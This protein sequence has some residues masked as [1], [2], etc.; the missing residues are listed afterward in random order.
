[1]E[2]HN[3]SLV[4]SEISEILKSTCKHFTINYLVSLLNSKKITKAI[5]FL[6]Q[7]NNCQLKTK[8]QNIFILYVFTILNTL[9]SKCYTKIYKLKSIN[10]NNKLIIL[11]NIVYICI[12]IFFNQMVLLL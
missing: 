11:Y 4:P 9:N 10:L 12:F 2:F 5:T 7:M 3:I 1:M 6:F 8:Y